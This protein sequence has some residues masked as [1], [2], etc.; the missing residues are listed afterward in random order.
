MRIP[1]PE[2]IPIWHAT[3]FAVCLAAIELAMGTNALFSGLVIIFIVTSTI[4][5]NMAGGLTRPSGS[6]VFFFA[7]LAVIIGLV[8]KCIFFEAADSNLKVPLITM[9]AY[10]AGMIV[11]LGAVWMSR[12]FRRRVGLL[13][14]LAKVED[15]RMASIGCIVAGIGVPLLAGLLVTAGGNVFSPL[16]SAYNQINHFLPM[17]I[18]LGVT[19]EIYG[20]GGKRSISVPVLLA[21]GWMYYNGVFLSFSKESLFL[22][23]VCWLATGAALR[24][25]FSRNQIV[26][27]LLALFLF[28]RYM[29]PY[30]QYGR[31]FRSDDNTYSQNL[32]V[33]LD[34]MSRLEEVRL[35]YAANIAMIDPRAANEYFNK[36]EGIF[37][38]LQMFGIDDALN[39]VTEEVGP[40]GLTPI[41]GYFLNAIPHVIWPGKPNINMANVYGH[42]VGLPE[43]DLT[44]S[45]SFSP[46]AEAYHDAKWIGVLAVAPCIWF[47]LFLIMDSLCGDTRK[48][49]WGILALSLFAHDAPEGLLG[50]PIYLMTFGCVI[51]SIIAFFSAYLLPLLAATLTGAKRKV[52]PVRDVRAVSARRPARPAFVPEPPSPDTSL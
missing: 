1:F 29:V 20:S 50:G 6:Y 49:P 32:A 4:A 14:N 11:M 36:Q 23:P 39:Y 48:S 51:I 44:T 25:R 31:S 24:Y 30:C 43:S 8:A 21:W 26:G 22:P 12:R 52:K 19:A 28:S 18:I 27:G 13:E 9:G 33:S 17:G 3:V 40:H 7:V 46:V 45:I 2:R 16:F 35:I 15:L 5:F 47:L 38:R 37:E 42:E 10:T 41:P 34:L